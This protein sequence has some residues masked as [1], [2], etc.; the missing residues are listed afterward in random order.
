MIKE[1]LKIRLQKIGKFGKKVSWTLGEQ[2]FL[3]FL[4]LFLLAV[5]FG[6]IVFYQST[7]SAKKFQPE[8]V[9]Q[10]LQFN[11]EL[12]E[13]VSIELQ[14]RQRK[15]EQVSTKQYPDPFWRTVSEELTE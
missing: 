14:E 10:P 6:G 4:V 15:F 5:L 1:N 13:K 9:K 2:A 7:I 11:E 3:T 12:F 8:V